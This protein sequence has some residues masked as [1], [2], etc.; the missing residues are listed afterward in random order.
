MANT[1]LL[2]KRTSISGAPAGGTLQPAQPAYAF[3]TDKLY[4]GNSSGSGILTV[5]GA[6]YTG[7]VDG[8][9]SANGANNLVKRDVNGDF[10]SR[11]ITAA[12]LIGPLTGTASLATALSPG[13][14][15]ASQGDVLIANTLFTGA[16]NINA[17]ATLAATGVVAGTYGEGTGGTKIPVLTIDTKGRITSAANVATPAGSSFTVQGNTGS[18]VVA[19]GSYIEIYGGDGHSGGVAVTSNTGNVIV[20]LSV[21]STV[22]RTSGTQSIG[23]LK[24]FT[25]DVVFSQNV[26]MSGMT[27]YANTQQLSVGDNI[28][29]LNADVPYNVPT[30]EN[31]GFEVNRGS[32]NGNTQIL[33]DETNKWW[34]AISNVL[35]AGASTLG[36]IHTDSYAN[37]T[38]LS[39]GTVPSARIAGSYT[40]I[41]GLGTITTGAWQGS[42]INVQWGGTGT[43]TFNTNGVLYS[44][45]ANGAIL[46]VAAPTEGQIFQGNISGVPVWGTI[47]GGVY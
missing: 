39:V 22:V 27:T 3:N 1:V 34:T 32:Y 24:T 44:P 41:T 18:G 31:A 37:A 12:M 2:F 11:N 42:L 15:I 17:T 46:S 40:G 13:A 23:G 43:S 33:W 7:I 47:D 35:V 9:T 21:D 45:G 6:Y 29:V 14:Y 25:N 38:S 26:T 16:T 30:I 19:S 36:R 8:A 28:I 4:I 10:Q 20:N 5:G